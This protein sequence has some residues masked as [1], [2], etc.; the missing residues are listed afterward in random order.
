M[1]KIL[2]AISFTLL[3]QA[4]ASV[5]SVNRPDSYYLQKQ[6]Q[7]LD[8][9]SNIPT[10]QSSE[11]I[12]QLLNHRIELPKQ[13]RVAIIN[14]NNSGLQGMPAISNNQ[15]SED[16]V[17]NFILKLRSSNRVYDASYLP[18]MLI[19]SR[20][21]IDTLR[22][23][24]ARMQ[25]DL[26]LA[27]QSACGSFSDFNLFTE[28]ESRSYC[29]VE[30]VLIDVRSGLV[31]LSSVSSQELEVKETS[32]DFNIYEMRSRAE[33]KATHQALA[34]VA[35]NVVNYFQSLEPSGKS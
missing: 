28:N 19:A 11:K 7:V 32:K 18:A 35:T 5:G 15:L 25:A 21:S 2:T 27:Y 6:P 17:E 34:E 14:L 30:A 20:R 31:A 10:S 9:A 24:A 1:I 22:L 3:L 4:C 16:L 13:N 33:V 8:I 29:T 23:S 12:A 26:I